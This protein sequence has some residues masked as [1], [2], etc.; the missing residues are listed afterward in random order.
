VSASRTYGTDWV[1]TGGLVPGE[2]I[3]T[4]GIG[5]LKKDQAI[6]PVPENTPQHVGPPRKGK[7]GEGGSGGSGA[8]R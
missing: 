4:Q 2:R 1:V 6:K 8:G 3:I 7:G 5:S